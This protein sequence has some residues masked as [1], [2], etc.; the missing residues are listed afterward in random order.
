MITHRSIPH[1]FHE[2]AANNKS[3]A[4]YKYRTDDAWVDVTWSE[5]D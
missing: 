5:A 4:A 3:K 1:L 2:V